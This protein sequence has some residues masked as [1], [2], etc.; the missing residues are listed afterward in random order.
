MERR[1]R[2]LVVG[3]GDL[4]GDLIATGL[5]L[6]APSIGKHLD[7]ARKTS[8]AVRWEGTITRGA[9]IVTLKASARNL[10][11]NE[12][13]RRAAPATKMVV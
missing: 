5:T 9:R 4:R 11:S 13:S 8:Q 3:R 7:E 2:T 10:R 6:S 12:G 1:V